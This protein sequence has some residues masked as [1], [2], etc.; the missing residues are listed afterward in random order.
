MTHHLG[1]PAIR[2]TARALLRRDEPAVPD[3]LPLP[4]RMWH[5]P[6]GV[7]RVWVVMELRRQRGTRT[8]SLEKRT[9]V[10]AR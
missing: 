1:S 3:S 8:L 4:S 9:L 7:A 2:S 10:H 5:E 6:A